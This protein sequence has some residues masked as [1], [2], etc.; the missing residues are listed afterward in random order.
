MVVGL[1]AWRAMRK[2]NIQV[3]MHHIGWVWDGSLEG[4]WTWQPHINTFV[5]PD[6]IPN[7]SG[8]WFISGAS[9]DLHK[10]EGDWHWYPSDEFHID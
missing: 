5:N 3:W 6:A 1:L 7:G 10:W 4:W 8:W 9:W 2:V